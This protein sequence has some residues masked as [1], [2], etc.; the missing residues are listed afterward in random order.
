MFWGGMICDYKQKA[1]L[2]HGSLLLHQD[3]I[4]VSQWLQLFAVA[5]DSDASGSL[6]WVCGSPAYC[7]ESY[8]GD[9]PGLTLEVR[10]CIDRIVV[11]SS[12]R[13]GRI[14]RGLSAKPCQHLNLCFGHG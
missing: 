5:S 10:A 11:E 2:L 13:H 7:V 1:E 6:R 4:T 14:H 12:H 3:K 9:I 8:D